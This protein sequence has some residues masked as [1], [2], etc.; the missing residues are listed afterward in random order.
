[1]MGAVRAALLLLLTAC[2]R[3]GFDARAF[4][5]GAS[6]DGAIVDHD[7]LAFAPCGT[8]V[9]LA[10]EFDD[11]VPGPFVVSTEPRMTVDE[12]NGTMNVTF[13]PSVPAGRYGWYRTATVY[14]TDGLCVTL[15]PVQAGDGGVVYMKLRTDEVEAEW[16]ARPASGLLDLRTRQ[17]SVPTVRDS[18][19]Y[20]LAVDRFWRLRQHGN[21]TLWETSTDGVQYR[22]HGVFAG[23]FPA[24]TAHLEFG[25]GAYE[26]VTNAG[27]ARFASVVITGP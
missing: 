27:V 2:G 21:T 17:G 7:V 16:F 20:D 3:V 5:D 4:D 14:P 12:A 15:A 19:P 23:V 26:N 25:A 9:L 18:I 6:P 1:M 10:D 13:A 11:G 8:T 24:A 22:T